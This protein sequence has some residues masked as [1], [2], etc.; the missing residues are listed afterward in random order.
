[1]GLTVVI[2]YL[3]FYALRFVP[4]GTTYHN[5]VLTAGLLVHTI[6]KKI[7]SIAI[8]NLPRLRL[9]NT[10]RLGLEACSCYHATK[11]FRLESVSIKTNSSHSKSPL[12]HCQRVSNL[13]YFQR[14]VVPK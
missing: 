9:S 2:R 1:M 3:N 5:I 13:T 7:I 8:F 6:Y 14:V 4:M 10:K 11:G 12:K